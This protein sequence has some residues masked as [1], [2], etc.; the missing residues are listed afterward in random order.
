[1]P[2][3]P[4]EATDSGPRCAFCGLLNPSHGHL[5]IHDAG[6]CRDKPDKDRK[7]TRK[8]GLI[9]HLKAHGMYEASALADRWR[10]WLRKR[11]CACGFCISIFSTNGDRL[12][13]IDNHHYRHHEHI[14]DWDHNIVIRGLLLQP[15]LLASWK[16]ICPWDPDPRNA[17]LIWDPHVIS[18]L[19]QRLELSEEPAYQLASDALRQSS[20]ESSQDIPPMSLPLGSFLNQQTDS[21]E[22][23]PAG[24][25]NYT[26]GPAPASYPAFNT[27][28]TDGASLPFQARNP[29]WDVARCNTVDPAQMDA[30]PPQSLVEFP[31]SAMA[32]SYHSSAT[33]H[34]TW[35]QDGV[36]NYPFTVQPLPDSSE[37]KAA[38]RPHYG[39]TRGQSDLAIPEISQGD[40]TQFTN[41]FDPSRIPQQ[42]FDCTAEPEGNQPSGR[43]ELSPSSRNYSTHSFST[44]TTATGS[45]KAPSIVGNVKRRFSRMKRGI[46][47]DDIMLHMQD[48]ERSRSALPT[49]RRSK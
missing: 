47:V 24:R 4:V 39:N 25:E 30:H 7:Y 33:A 45:A 6:L 35:H 29:P 42:T 16:K 17:K 9:N 1:M 46:D 20:A 22:I 2:N 28:D 41:S 36:T 12:N 21:A 13:H 10:V 11:F 14:D 48:D 49:D 15:E 18:S 44:V 5:E 23:M 34:S 26:L 3:G 32:D 8:L 27:H 19:Q 40:S 37:I 43:P 38:T 31:D